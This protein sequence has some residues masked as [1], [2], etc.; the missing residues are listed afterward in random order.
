MSGVTANRLRR[1]VRGL[2]ALA[3]RGVQLPPDEEQS[4]TRP[5]ERE[6]TVDGSCAVSSPG[7]V[8]GARGER[9]WQSD[10]EAAEPTGPAGSR[11][12][13]APPEMPVDV[14]L[15]R[16]LR[17]I[18]RQ[19]WGRAQRV[20]EDMVRTSPGCEAS[21]YLS[22]VRAVR[23]CLRRLRRWPRDAQ[24]H[25]ELGRLY[26]GL[27][28]GDEALREFRQV[29]EL[30]PNIAEGHFLLALEYL[31]RGDDAAARQCCQQA[32]RLKA[33]LPSYE[34]LRR[35]LSAEGRDHAQRQVG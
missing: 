15:E 12:S 32:L 21:A 14:C 16:G 5:P 10:A 27:E 3:A 20:L 24:T 30:D 2:A 18:R 26:F 29:V 33:D 23:R 31:F 25:L 7:L 8:S 17:H 4:A 19:E 22:E 35:A 9:G 13:P 1:F 28:L 6:A 34:D 11:E